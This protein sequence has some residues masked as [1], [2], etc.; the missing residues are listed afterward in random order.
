M[1]FDDMNLSEDLLYGIYASGFETSFATQQG[2]ILPCVKGVMMRLL[3]PTLGL[4]KQLNLPYQFFS[5]SKGQSL[6]FLVLAFTHELAQQI[7]NLVMAL[8]DCVDASCV[9]CL[10]GTNEH[11]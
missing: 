3:K 8:G 1:R 6:L 5:T 11:A 9:A 10:G 2:A 7:Q 4:G